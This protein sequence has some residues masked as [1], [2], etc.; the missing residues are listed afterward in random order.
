VED[1][2][3]Y[4]DLGNISRRDSSSDSLH[5][6]VQHTSCLPRGNKIV[7]LI[8]AIFSSMRDEKL[9]SAV[10][11]QTPSSMGESFFPPCTRHVSM[12]LRPGIVILKF[13][14]TGYLF[15]SVLSH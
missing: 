4:S 15:I 3:L 12:Y 10:R 8:R 7:N 14:P 11:G 2:N 6:I 5:S 13:C 9:I 1:K